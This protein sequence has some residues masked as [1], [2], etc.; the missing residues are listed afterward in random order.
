M[1]NRDN[2][3]V[4]KSFLAYT[5]D[6][7]QRDVRTVGRYWSHLRHLL[8]WADET[9]LSRAADIR[10]SFPEYL[11]GVR[12][13]GGEEPLKPETL[14]KIVQTSKALLKWARLNYARQVRGL[15]ASWIEALCPPRNTRVENEK[16]HEF[17]SL[18]EVLQL[19]RMPVPEADLALRRDQA[20]AAMLFLSGMRAGA[21]ATLPLEAVDLA[22]RSVRQWPSLGVHTKF[23]KSAT[24]Y[25]L[26]VPELL[27]SVERWDTFVRAQLPASAM[28][29]TPIDGSWGAQRLL[30][31]GAGANRNIAL[32]KRLRRLCAAA[33]LPFKSAHKFRHGHAV[34]AASA[35]PA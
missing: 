6:T 14:K 8:L 5:Q 26:E 13:D 10:P 4:V 17:A 25:L 31:A 21:L 18:A 32:G 11:A 29:Y 23:G 28:W 19:I 22:S 33:G 12:R 20:G 30:P 2:Y 34:W 3:H 24:T 16:K 7:R 27:A 9:P 1:V 15:P 35:S